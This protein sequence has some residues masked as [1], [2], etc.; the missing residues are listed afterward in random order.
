[1][2]YFTSGSGV[3]YKNSWTNVID[4]S[5]P[6]AQAIADAANF[7][8]TIS[9]SG[10]TWWCLGDHKID[11][12]N[13]APWCTN[14]NQSTYAWIF[15]HIDGCSV[16]GCTDDSDA[17]D[18]YWTSDIILNS[19]SARIVHGYIGTTDVTYQLGLR[20]VITVLKDNL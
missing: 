8:L 11:S 12:Q 13:N 19:K 10:L 2:K 14:N 16:E 1:M 17:G 20:P 5:M 4:I 3:T 6:T 9:D 15:N 7:G 18:Y